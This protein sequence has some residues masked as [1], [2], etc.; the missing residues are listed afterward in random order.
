[1]N[2]KGVI[3]GLLGGVGCLVGVIVFGGVVVLWFRGAAWVSAHLLPWMIGASFFTFCA[4]LLVALPLSFFRGPRPI[5]GVTVYLSSY[6]FGATVWM[7]ALLLTLSI[8]GVGAVV[9]GLLLGGIGVV[10]IAILATLFHAQWGNMG[11]L[12]LMTALTF[13]TRSCGAWLTATPDRDDENRE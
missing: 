2:G 9:V 11:I 12:V 10:P 8:W 7:N 13:G 3:G 5:I 4:L 6:L 1:M